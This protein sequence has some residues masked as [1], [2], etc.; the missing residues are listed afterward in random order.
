MKSKEEKLDEFVSKVVGYL[1]GAAPMGENWENQVKSYRKVTFTK[2]QSWIMFFATLAMFIELLIARLEDLP[3]KE[4]AK[5]LEVKAIDHCG[6][7]F[8]LL[9]SDKKELKKMSA[10]PL[11]GNDSKK[12]S[13]IK[14]LLYTRIKTS[15]ELQI[16]HDLTVGQ[17]YFAFL[18]DN[19]LD[20]SPKDH[21]N[22]EV[23]RDYI[24]V[25]AKSFEDADVRGE[26]LKLFP[27]VDK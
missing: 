15:R 25:K 2:D 16:K 10:L 23:L 24:N 11:A 3:T 20:I 18:R 13:F 22:E 1:Y 21:I 9:N 8:E 7:L 26:Y 4:E 27:N 6:I 19:I 12:K 5:L 14:D 17:Y